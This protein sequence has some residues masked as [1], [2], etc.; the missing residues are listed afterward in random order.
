MNSSYD[1]C[2]II[3]ENNICI[4]CFSGFHLIK[5]KCVIGTITNCIEYDTDFEDQKC[6]KC[7]QDYRLG[8]NNKSCLLGYLNYCKFYKNTAETSCSECLTQ[9]LTFNYKI[10]NGY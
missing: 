3:D 1:N 6:T 5:K 7:A 9:G 10:I 8:I 4:S 2:V